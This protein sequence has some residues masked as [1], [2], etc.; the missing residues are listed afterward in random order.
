MYIHY[1]TPELVL[2]DSYRVTT[3][4]QVSSQDL[5]ETIQIDDL[6]KVLRT[7]QLRCHGHV[8]RS[9][10]WLKETQELDPTGFRG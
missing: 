1:K 7:R 2:T 3:M 5:L 4:D 9:D 8:E 10:G 6:P